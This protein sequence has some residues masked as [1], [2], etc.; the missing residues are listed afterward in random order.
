M[1]RTDKPMG[2]TDKLMGRTDKPM[3][4][5]DKP[6]GRTDK[7][8]ERQQVKTGQERHCK[9]R[10]SHIHFRTRKDRSRH[11]EAGKIRQEQIVQVQVGKS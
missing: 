2:R 4:R 5:A 11:L 1:G 10:T 7:Q 8:M 6:I 3:G 9:V